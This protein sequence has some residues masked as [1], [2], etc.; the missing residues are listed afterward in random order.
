MI[1]GFTAFSKDQITWFANA[2]NGTQFAFDV[3]R[4]TKYNKGFD[5][6]KDFTF[7]SRFDEGEFP[8]VICYLTSCHSFTGKGVT[9]VSL[10]LDKPERIR[11]FEEKTR[12]RILSVLN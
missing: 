2:M 4:K 8:S 5:Y 9:Y 10:E 12:H 1:K 11:Q 3:Q 6:G 7:I